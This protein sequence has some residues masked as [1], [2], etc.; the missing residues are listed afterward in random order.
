MDAEGDIDLSLSISTRD[1]CTQLARCLESL[2]ALEFQRAGE[3]VLVD[4]R[5]R[6][7]TPQ[8]IEKFAK[9]PRMSLRYLLE[10][11]VGLRVAHN[12]SAEQ[13][14]G[15]P[16]CS[17]ANATVR[18]R[19][20]LAIHG[21]FQSCVRWHKSCI[22]FRTPRRQQYPLLAV[23]LARDPSANDGVGGDAGRR[24]DRRWVT[25]PMHIAYSQP[26]TFASTTRPRKLLTLDAPAWT[27]NSWT[28]ARPE[29]HITVET[30]GSDRY[31]SVANV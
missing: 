6:D 18:R 28:F 16:L 29:R 2:Q 14:Q 8:L 22:D 12:R 4:N 25:S 13:S 30:S 21:E 19:R 27:C 15:V 10:P 24:T 3:L 17:Q 5:S 11:R 9:T 26:A 23:E 7:E 20:L 31:F 1:R